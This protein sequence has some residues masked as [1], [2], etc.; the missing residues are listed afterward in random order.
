[1]V[2]TLDGEGVTGGGLAAGGERY[3]CPVHKLN[4]VGRSLA[5]VGR[6][7]PPLQACCVMLVARP[8]HV[9]S[10]ALES[11]VNGTSARR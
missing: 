7:G 6:E 2:T 3:R 4:M 5:C 9:R 8:R 10:S 1:M 11:D